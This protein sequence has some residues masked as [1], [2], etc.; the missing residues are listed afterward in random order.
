VLL[1]DSFGSNQ[2][3]SAYAISTSVVK[4]A[5]PH[6]KWPR[7]RSVDPCPCLW[8]SDHR[9]R[10]LRVNETETRT[11]RETTEQGL[12][13]APDPSELRT[14][15]VCVGRKHVARLMKGQGLVGARRRRRVRTTVRGRSRHGIPDLVQRLFQANE[16]DPLWVAD[17]AYV[18]VLIGFLYSAV[19]LDAFSRKVSAR[20]RHLPA[21]RRASE[22]G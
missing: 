2:I 17:I 10:T 6:S 9:A 16:T 12:G 8:M 13:R 5:R 19:V 15:G 11:R 4:H 20:G 21:E 14:Q 3:L 1:N 18:P 22:E 7:S